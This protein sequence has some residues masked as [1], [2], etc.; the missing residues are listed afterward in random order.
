MTAPATPLHALH[1]AGQSIWLDFID[2]TLL[3]RADPE[4]MG[5]RL[6]LRD[7]S[8]GTI[9]AFH[10]FMRRAAEEHDRRGGAWAFSRLSHGG[11]RGW[12]ARS[13]GHLRVGLM[14]LRM[15]IG[16][17]SRVLRILLLRSK[18]FLLAWVRREKVSVKLFALRKIQNTVVLTF[19]HPTLR[20]EREGWGTPIS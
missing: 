14:T 13:Q 16:L 10:A 1:A 18:N 12:P 6:A 19:A 9:D 5:W 15:R 11:H 20:K 7:R 2:R 3:E 4:V 8:A 17:R